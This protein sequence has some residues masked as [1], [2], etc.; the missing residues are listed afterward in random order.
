LKN[1]SPPSNAAGRR[2]HALAAEIEAVG[3][4]SVQ[5]ALDREI[6]RRAEAWLTGLEAYR[7][8]PFRRHR[9]SP[10]VVWHEGTTRLL[11]YGAG[12]GPT[13]LVIPSLINRYYVLDLLPERSFLRHLAGCALRPLVIDWGAPGREE[14]HFD[15]SGYVVERLDSAFTAA[16]QTAGAPIAI[17]GYC[18]GGLLALASALRHRSRVACVALLATPW[19]FHAQSGKPPLLA[20]LVDWL[21]CVCAP[22]GTLP[23]EAIQ[24]LFF[25]LDPFSAERKFSRFAAVDHESDEARR[26]VALEDWINDGVPLA[27]GVARECANSWYGD[28]Q[29][30]KGSWRVA[31]TLVRPQSLGRPVIAVVPGRDRIV[32]P[33]SAEPLAAALGS[34]TVL[35]PPLGHIGMMAAIDAPEMLWTPVAAWLRARL[36]KG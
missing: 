26:F 33:A 2:L 4:E 12:A 29:P 25:L 20:L 27:I 35:R 34:A 9:V 23:V 11:D 3:A 13:V 7:G 24:A 1:A 28:N 17:V 22:A 16:S 14:R 18:M 10:P 15:V 5:R 6:E 31:G 8:H 30:A 19:D 36:W 32:P 21:A